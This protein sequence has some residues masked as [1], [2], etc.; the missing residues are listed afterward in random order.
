MKDIATL[1]EKKKKSIYQN[2]FAFF[3]IWIL[4]CGKFWIRIFL[5]RNGKRRAKVKCLE[6][7]L[8]KFMSYTMHRSMNKF[9]V[10][11][12]VYIPEIKQ[13]NSKLGYGRIFCTKLTTFGNRYDSVFYI[14]VQ[15]IN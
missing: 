14:T 9:Q 8:H 6:G 7:Q 4:H 5:L 13:I 12:L 1:K 10:C 2:T 3:R 11:F 15:I